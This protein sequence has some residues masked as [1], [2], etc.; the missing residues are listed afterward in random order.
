MNSNK[1][2]AEGAES[3]GTITKS[4]S[5][6]FN[7]DP[8][9]GAIALNPGTFN[10]KY[11]VLLNNGIGVPENA[12]SCCAFL[13]SSAIWNFDANVRDNNNRIYF[14]PNAIDAETFITIPQGYY[15]ISELNAQ[16]SLQL[17]LGGF[18]T[19]TFFFSGDSATQKVIVNFGIDGT[20]LNFNPVDAEGLRIVLGFD[21]RYSPATAPGVPSAAGGVDVADNVASFNSVNAFLINTNLVL[22]G[23]PT[24]ALGTSTLG[25]VP[26]IESPNFLISYSPSVPI[27]IDCEHLIGGDYT[28]VT[29]ELTNELLEPVVVLDSF[30]YTLTIEYTL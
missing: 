19:N 21:E 9:S 15:G 13:S 11:K 8:K 14:K 23:L 24:N 2:I 26:I 17:Q 3:K 30:S 27:K 25:I 28:D 20:Y 5:I 12:R 7:S 18:P 16:I 6:S 1:Y 10:N 22:Q 4:Y 29:F